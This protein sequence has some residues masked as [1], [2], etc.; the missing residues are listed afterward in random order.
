MLRLPLLVPQGGAVHFIPL[1]ILSSFHG[2]LYNGHEPYK[3][4]CYLFDML[5]KATTLEERLSLLPYRLD[6]AAY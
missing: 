6:P 4:L 2:S 1:L 5:P 3:Y